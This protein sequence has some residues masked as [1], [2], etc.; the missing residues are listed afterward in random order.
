MNLTTKTAFRLKNFRDHMRI[1]DNVTLAGMLKRY[2]RRHPRATAIAKGSTVLG[3]VYFLMMSLLPG[4]S[5]PLQKDIK[6]SLLALYLSPHSA[7]ESQPRRGTTISSA[8]TRSSTSS[9]STKL[10]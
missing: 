2:A 9:S 6:L 10:P 3:G 8:Q 4:T 1:T 7:P 5:L